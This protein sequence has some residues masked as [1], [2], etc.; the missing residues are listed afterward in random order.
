MTTEY[1]LTCDMSIGLYTEYFELLCRKQK[2]YKLRY[3]LA[4]SSG[5][6]LAFLKPPNVSINDDITS[7]IVT[8][9]VAVLIQIP[10]VTIFVFGILTLAA[11]LPKYTAV[12]YIKKQPNELWGKYTL[13]IEK[14]EVIISNK[15]STHIFKSNL[16]DNI[17]ETKAGYHLIHGQ[18]LLISIPKKQGLLN[19]IRKALEKDFS[20]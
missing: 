17:L 7:S 18:Q 9:I 11:S 2:W 20:T 1:I 13:R 4:L 12:Q 10:L 3:I 8:V 5:V 6:T 16:V 19:D 15:L 14:G